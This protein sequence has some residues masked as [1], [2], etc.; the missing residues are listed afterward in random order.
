MHYWVFEFLN[1]AFLFL[2]GLIPN[3][4]GLNDLRP[5]LSKSE[6]VLK[7]LPLKF[8]ESCLA[9]VGFERQEIT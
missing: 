8:V 3:E 1:D 2:E 6:H 5:V 7:A 4:D 9:V